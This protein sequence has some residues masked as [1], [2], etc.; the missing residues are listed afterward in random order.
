MKQLWFFKKPWAQH[1]SGIIMPIF[2]TARTCTTA[3]GFQH[4]KRKVRI[5]CLPCDGMLVV[6][7]GSSPT[8]YAHTQYN[9]ICV[10]YNSFFMLLLHKFCMAVLACCAFYMHSWS[11]SETALTLTV[12]L[13]FLR[14]HNST[15]TPYLYL[16]RLP[17]TLNNLSNWQRR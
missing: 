10:P 12:F 7:D 9:A 1:V 17:A 14:Q 16:I 4:C 8:L 6:L 3:C 15:A 11:A 5:R 13:L 2:R